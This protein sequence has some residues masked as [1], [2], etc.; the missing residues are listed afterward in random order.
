MNSLILGIGDKTQLLLDLAR[1]PFLLID[2]GPI[3]DTFAAHFPKA[4]QFDLSTHS[5]NPLK[6]MDYKKARDFVSTVYSAS[7]EGENTLTVRNGKRALMKLLL[8]NTTR[9]DHLKGQDPEATAMI[10]DMLLS[11]VLKNVL[12]NPTNVSFKKSVIVRLNRAEIGD[13]D[14]FLLGSL[15][16]GQHK[17]QVI[18]PDF[19]FYGRNTNLIRQE[20]LLAGV[21]FLSELTLPLRQAASL[22]RDKVPCQCSWED[23]AVLA[24]YAGLQDGTVG[25]STFMENAT[26]PC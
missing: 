15:L 14:A 11:P 7:P 13:Y 3:A 22:I 25:H 1:S 17:G 26:A 8:A 10:E 6:G 21:N 9:L 5:F 24:R 18:V 2:D 23:A 16:I 12:C 19:G 4:L 20:R